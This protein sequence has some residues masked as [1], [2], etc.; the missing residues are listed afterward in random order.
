M[1]RLFMGN[2]MENRNEDMWG[3]RTK[4]IIFLGGY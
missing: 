1:A 2:C 3:V 4:A